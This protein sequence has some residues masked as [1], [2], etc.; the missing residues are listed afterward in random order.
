MPSPLASQYNRDIERLR[1]RTIAQMSR[2]IEA[3]MRRL[4][5]SFATAGLSEADIAATL[6]EADRQLLALLTPQY[7]AATVGVQRILTAR[8]GLATPIDLQPILDAAGQ[9]IVTING[10][11]RDV[12]RRQ[13]RIAIEL[14]LSDG[15]TE[16]LIRGAVGDTYR[17]ER[18]ARTESAFATNE[19][20]A[21]EYAAEGIDQVEVFDGADCG[22]TSHND[23]LKANGRIV[24]VAESQR[25]PISHPNCQRAFAPVV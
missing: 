3:Y 20:A 22:W 9:R 16:R 11:A 24:S 23:P 19:A 15:D 25:T 12:V 21:Q 7:R 13:L 14:N 1:Q 17:A 6:V 4:G 5:R 2:R 10:T 8:Y 18:I